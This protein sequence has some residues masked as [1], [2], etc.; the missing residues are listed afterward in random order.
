MARDTVLD[1][2]RD[3]HPADAHDP[4]Q[5]RQVDDA[6]QSR[7]VHAVMQRFNA[8]GAPLPTTEVRGAAHA[9]RRSG[10]VAVGG[11]LGPAQDR[12]LRDQRRLCVARRAR[13]GVTLSGAQKQN[14]GERDHDRDRH[15]G[16]GDDRAGQ[17]ADGPPEG[18]AL[19]VRVGSVG[20]GRE[21]DELAL[22]VGQ[23]CHGLTSRRSR[24]RDNPR[25]TR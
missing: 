23:D 13:R 15:R 21:I 10:Y 19:P 18:R 16:R 14:G 25:L 24:I 4:G 3:A 1:E 9:R 2:Q 20:S 6:A 22:E 12:V 7:D 5:G 8:R 17:R 11:G